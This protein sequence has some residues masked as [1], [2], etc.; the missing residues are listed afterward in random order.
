MEILIALII[1]DI[2]NLIVRFV[3]NRE[4]TPKWKK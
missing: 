3:V 4:E 1:L 2:I